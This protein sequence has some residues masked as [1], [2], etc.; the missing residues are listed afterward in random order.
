[1]QKNLVQ[2]KDGFGKFSGIECVNMPS[3]GDDGTD[4]VQTIDTGDDSGSAELN[5]SDEADVNLRDDGDDRDG[6]DFQRE[7]FL[8]QLEKNQ[9]RREVRSF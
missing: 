1:M 5:F 9:F 2:R 4:T 6:D 3:Q 7:R 8:F